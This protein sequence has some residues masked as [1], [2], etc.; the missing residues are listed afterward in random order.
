MYHLAIFASMPCRNW[1]LRNWFKKMLSRGRVEIDLK[2][3]GAIR[4]PVLLEI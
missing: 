3:K 2:V 1:G 4:D